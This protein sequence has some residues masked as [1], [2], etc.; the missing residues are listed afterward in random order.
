RGPSR[1]TRDRTTDREGSGEEH[2]REHRR[3]RRVPTLRKSRRGR[4]WLFVTLGAF[5]P[6]ARRFAESKAN[7][8]LIDGDELVRLTIEYYNDLDPKYKGVLPLR[9]VFVPEAIDQAP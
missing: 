8:R 9:Q 7:L 6:Q 4:I 3:T 5:T 1:R 2:R